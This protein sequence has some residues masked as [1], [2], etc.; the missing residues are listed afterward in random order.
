MLPYALRIL[1][2]ALAAALAASPGPERQRSQ[3]QRSEQPLRQQP[4]CNISADIDSLC[5]SF[6][7]DECAL[8]NATGG[9]SGQP[10]TVT[11]YR[12][13]PAAITDMLNKDAGD[14]AGDL[15]FFLSRHNLRQMCAAD[16]H[17]HGNGCFLAGQDVI[18]QYEVHVDGRWGPCKPKADILASSKSRS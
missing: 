6:C 3:P 15:S 2:T 13:T 16:P 10:E 1:A 4:A 5:A 14:P 12:L 17:A 8:Y 18:V 7:A 11:V 9:E